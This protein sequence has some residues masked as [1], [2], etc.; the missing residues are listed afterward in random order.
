MADLAFSGKYADASGLT[1]PN[2][3]VTSEKFFIVLEEIL[4]G[5]VSESQHDE[6]KNWLS[7][8][9]G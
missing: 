7:L 5:N 8:C 9:K 6:N 4:V 3:Q 2:A 1:K